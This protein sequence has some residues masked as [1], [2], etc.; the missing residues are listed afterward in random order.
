MDQQFDV[1]IIGAGPGGYVAAIK[2]AQ[3]GLNVGIVDEKPV[4][5]G[6]CL[7]EGCIPSKA[8]LN[9]SYKLYE[10]Q[11]RFSELGIKVESVRADLPEML[12]MKD[13]TIQDLTRGIAFLFKKN[14]VTF[15]QG[16]GMIQAPGHVQLTPPQGAPQQIQAKAIILATGSHS[17]ALPGIDIDE[18]RVLSS[19]G[20]L[21]LSRIPKHLVVIGAGYIGLELGSIWSRLGAQV[22][23]LEYAD[24]CIPM[25]DSEMGDALQKSLVQQGMTFHYQ[26]QVTHVEQKGNAL[27]VHMQSTQE[28]AEPI[29]PLECDHVLVAAGRKPHTQN[30]GL[31]N[32]NI[33]PNTHGYIE[34][35]RQFQTT[36][37]GIY[38]IGDVIPGPMLAHKAEAEGIAVAEILAGHAGHVH[39]ETIPSVIYTAPEVAS[40]GLT[41]SDVKAQGI[42]YRVGKFPFLANSRAK[43]VLET[44][45]FVKV[46]THETTDRVLGVHIIGSQAGHMIAEA[47]LAMEF[48]A[49]AEDIARTCHA[50]PTFSEALAEASMMAYDKAIH[51]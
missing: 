29:A 25:V 36:C 15:L 24:R 5:G 3:L 26:R 16:R 32:V 14:K 22:T 13:N 49:S 6:T 51:T 4:A 50:H 10:A 27:M 42:P 39:Y 47:V 43:T 18:K 46:L 11:T 2:A 19:T 30:L 17:T 31:E 41:E 33:I 7:N 48:C 38:A 12:K 9:A 34:V 35:D 21:S 1:L 20:A 37:P 45:G 28:N 40:V 23:V 44:T 8:L